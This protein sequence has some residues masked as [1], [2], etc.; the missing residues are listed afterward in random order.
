MSARAVIERWNGKG[1]TSVLVV[2][3]PTLDADARAIES[4]LR[5][6]GY[7]VMLYSSTTGE[8]A[9]VCVYGKRKPTIAAVR[10]VCSELRLEVENRT[11]RQ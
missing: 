7:I 2:G 9:Q 3:G 10:E 8:S 5:A 4:K 6:S 11:E 1:F